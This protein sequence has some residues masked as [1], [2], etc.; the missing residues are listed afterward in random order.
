MSVTIET[1]VRYIETAQG[2]VLR[3]EE[4]WAVSDEARALLGKTATDGK[5]VDEAAWVAWQTANAKALKA[6]ND[7]LMPPNKEKIKAKEDDDA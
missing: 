5:E 4:T 3:V 2:I 6:A 7:R 1:V